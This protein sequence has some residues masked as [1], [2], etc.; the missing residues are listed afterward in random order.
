[1]KKKATVL[2][3][4]DGV[5]A[6]F[7]EVALSIIAEKTGI[8]YSAE[9]IPRWDIFESMGLPELWE[10]L[11][12]RA[13]RKGFC[14]SIRP[15]SP[16]IMGVKKLRKKYDVLCVTAPV[17][18]L[19]WMYE[20]AHW[21]EEHFDIPRKKVI[22]AHEKHHVHGDV[23]VDDKPDNVIAW[24][25]ANPDGVAVLWEHPYNEKVSLPEGIVRCSDW[26]DL[27]STLKDLLPDD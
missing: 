12:K 18:A 2:L 13:N 16:A 27:L 22:F 10:E 21:L 7:T 4:C 5:L 24:A 1:V 20:R 15:Y 6:D 23:L 11:V 14:S 8:V 26:N 17:D 25:E 3:D 19:P 9:D